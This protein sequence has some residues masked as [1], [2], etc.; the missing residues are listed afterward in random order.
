LAAFLRVMRLHGNDSASLQARSVKASV[1]RDPRA[2]LTS[3]AWRES[4]RFTSTGCALIPGI[5]L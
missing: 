4:D 1:S 2:V 5:A 3:A